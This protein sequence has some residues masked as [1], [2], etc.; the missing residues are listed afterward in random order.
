MSALFNLAEIRPA[1]LLHLRSAS[2]VTRVG[3]K[4]LSDRKF[5][6]RGFHDALVLGGMIGVGKA[7][8]LLARMGG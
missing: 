4:V 6:V 7:L 5:K 2:F 1:D 3:T 8:W